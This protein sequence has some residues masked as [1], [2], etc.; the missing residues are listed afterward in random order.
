MAVRAEG[1][2][3]SPTAPDPRCSTRSTSSIAAGVVGGGRRRDRLGQDHLR[4]AA[5]PAGRPDRR[6][7]AARRH[8]RARAHAPRAGCGRSAWCPRTASC[9]TP[10][11]P[12]TCG[13]GGSAPPT[14][15]SPRRSR[16][17]GS[18][19]GWRRLPGRPRHAGRR[20]GQRA[21]GR[22]APARRPDPGPA[23][24]PR[25]A[26]PRRGDQ[27]GRP[28][29]RT[30]ARR[31]PAAA[32]GRAH[33][34][35]RGPPPL[36]RRAGRHGPRVRPRAAR[37]ARP[38]RRARRRR[39]HL[40]PAAP[41]LARHD[42]RRCA[43]TA[44][45]VGGH[46]AGSVRSTTSLG[47]A[48][49]RPRSGTSPPCPTNPRGHRVDH[50]R[51]PRPALRVRGSEPPAQPRSPPDARPTWRTTS[52]AS[53]P[54]ARSV[55]VPNLADRV[56]EVRHD[57]DRLADFV[58]AVADALRAADASW[59]ARYAR[60]GGQPPRAPAARGGPP[61]GRAARSAGSTSACWWPGPSA[62]A[63]GSPPRAT[64][65]A[66]SSGAAPTTSPTWSRCG[67]TRCSSRSGYGPLRAT[68]V[69]AAISFRMWA[70][71]ATWDERRR[72]ALGGLRAA[73]HAQDQGRDLAVAGLR[74]V[75]GWLRAQLDGALGDGDPGPVVVPP[76]L[77]LPRPLRLVAVDALDRADAV[78]GTADAAA[79]RAA[80]PRGA[81]PA[82]PR[83]RSPPHPT[84][85]STPG[86]GRWTRWPTTSPGRGDRRGVQN[87]GVPELPEVETV[88]RQL[89]P[90]LV[91]PPHHR[92]RAATGRRSSTPPPRRS[93]SGD[94]GRRPA[95]QVP[96]DRPRRR[97]RADRPPRHDRSPPPP[98]AR[99]PSR[100]R[101]TGPG[102]RSTTGAS[103]TSTTRVASGG[104]RSCPPAT[105]AACRCCT[106]SARAV[107]RRLHRASVCGGPSG[108][109][110]RG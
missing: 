88:R 23:G 107:R 75:T 4:Q 41:E 29:D 101:T 32:G 7:R 28:R 60:P 85:C 72:L 34:G 67:S 55:A 33:H 78:A 105:T 69:A 16:S 104:S 35:E 42:P 92:R 79:D 25:P 26:R 106:T 97:P 8:R 82:P 93:A 90:L 74:R 108:P 1:V 71:L 89:E 68:A 100:A 59:L 64:R 57:L 80:A 76:P 62:T 40:H 103:S 44:P 31:R 110:R 43:T 2:S 63:G 96:P 21:V 54:G 52:A 11:W 39:G 13:S 48:G 36:H 27:R 58:D 91:G 15:S 18:P 66:P 86:P 22:R 53:G 83:R 84:P 102:G 12:R 20:A 45:I 87:Q 30:G 95:G 37:R 5:V 99:R 49:E 77:P 56:H 61:P 109:A 17:S 6:P 19:P 10:R 38:A 51:P 24:R 9:S 70:E 3:A 46:G 81:L 50:Q 14:T 94:R 47:V 73:D 65:S 98:G